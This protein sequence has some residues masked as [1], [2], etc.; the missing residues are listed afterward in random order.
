MKTDKIEKK[1][2][3]HYKRYMRS[4]KNIVAKAEKISGEQLPIDG[5]PSRTRS[6]NISMASKI[7][8]QSKDCDLDWAVVNTN[9][10]RICDIVEG[11]RIYENNNQ[12]GIKGQHNL[13]QHG[14]LGVYRALN[15]YDPSM[16]TRLITFIN[17]NVYY[18]FGNTKPGK[19]KEMFA[20]TG[21]AEID[22]KQY[23]KMLK[24]YDRICNGS[25]V[26][27]NELYGKSGGELEQWKRHRE[28]DE[29]G[30]CW[31]DFFQLENCAAW[32]VQD[33]YELKNL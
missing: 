29:E 7:L 14:R 2:Q 17:R 21:I 27:F 11:L 1:L 25:K 13:Y 10:E 16:G 30:F 23:W 22:I 26:A 4:I 3:K 12:F 24:A 8:Q 19:A 5:V 18:E 20:L 15:K 6:E 9:F 28:N 32:N 33:I 31:N